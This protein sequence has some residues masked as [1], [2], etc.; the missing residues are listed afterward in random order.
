MKLLAANTFPTDTYQAVA[1]TTTGSPIFVGIMKFIIIP[2]TEGLLLFTVL[3][4]IW[5]VFGLIMHADDPAARATGQ[6]HILWGLVGLFI[7][8]SSYG[9]IR[10][11]GNTVGVDPF[12]F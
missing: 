7:M 2:I 3:I 1:Q 4:F 5:G 6:K 10:V 11:I 12:P 9:I 8:I